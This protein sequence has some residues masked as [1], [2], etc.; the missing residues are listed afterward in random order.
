MEKSKV[1]RVD[2]ARLNK[3]QRRNVAEKL[4]TISFMI[5]PHTSIQGILAYD[6]IEDA[7]RT[8]KS[9]EEFKFMLDLPDE[10]EV[11]DVT[12]WGLLH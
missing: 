8:F 5:I 1:F 10:C 12:G 9:P 2:V 6:A 4:E 7:S 3:E 11:I